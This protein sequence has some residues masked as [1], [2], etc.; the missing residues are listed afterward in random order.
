MKSHYTRQ[1]TTE[2]YSRILR[3]LIGSYLSNLK[4]KWKWACHLSSLV[5]AAACLKCVGFV[6]LTSGSVVDAYCPFCTL[7][8][9]AFTL[10]KKSISVWLVSP[11][12][13]NGAQFLLLC[14]CQEGP[15][16]VE[17]LFFNYRFN[18][19]QRIQN[20]QAKAGAVSKDSWRNAIFFD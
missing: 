2:P 17:T 1:W 14:T 5:N 12:L 11:R 18:T 3:A 9:P 13:F 16:K 4:L 8:V 10:E 19:S 7:F 15:G 20:L 6:Q